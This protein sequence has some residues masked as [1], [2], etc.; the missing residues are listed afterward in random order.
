ML[1]ESVMHDARISV[2]L[3]VGDREMQIRRLRATAVRA[4]AAA[5]AKFLS[6]E[7]LNLRAI[8]TPVRFV[9]RALRDAY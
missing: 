8:K 6:L 4:R 2:R 3:R 9:E 5:G 7:R 1:Y